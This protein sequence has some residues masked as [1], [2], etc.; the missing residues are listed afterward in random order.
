MVAKKKKTFKKNM[1]ILTCGTLFSLFLPASST[2]S[3]ATPRDSRPSSAWLAR[4]LFYATISIEQLMEVLT[5]EE[6]DQIDLSVLRNIQSNSK[7]KKKPGD[8]GD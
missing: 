7:S 4:N 2:P 1:A 6:L 8:G 3:D 5:Q